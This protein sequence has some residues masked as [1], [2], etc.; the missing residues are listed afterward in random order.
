ME[1]SSAASTALLLRTR[2]HARLAAKAQGH[3]GG[4]GGS[5]NSYGRGVK[6]KGKQ[7]WRGGDSREHKGKGK[8]GGKGKGKKGKQN[9]W[10]D[11]DRQGD[12]DWE[13]QQG[14]QGGQIRSSP[15]QSSLEAAVEAEWDFFFG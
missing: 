3:D 7:D 10:Q 2:K 9:W 14:E 12:Q 4:G 15:E 11:S 5:W 6:G 1:E 13:G 8:K